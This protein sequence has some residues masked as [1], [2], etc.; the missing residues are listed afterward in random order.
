MAT[1]SYNINML[2]VFPFW[3][4]G[5]NLVD[6]TNSQNL[7]ALSLL[8]CTEDKECFENISQLN[9]FAI[10]FFFLYVSSVHN[11]ENTNRF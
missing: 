6:F 8:L 7:L 9:H 11:N 1:V 4:P 10:F 2:H 5:L 3:K